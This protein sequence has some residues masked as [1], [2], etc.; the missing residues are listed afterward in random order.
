VQ[1]YRRE[2]ARG[3]ELGAEG[4][5]DAPPAQVRALLLDYERAPAWVSGVHESR[6]VS[7]SDQ[8]LVV[9]QRLVLPLLRDRDFTLRVSWGMEQGREWLRFVADGGAGPPPVSGAIRVTHHE[10]QWLLSPIDGGRRTHAVYRFALDLGGAVPM[11]LGKGRAAK[12]LAGLFVALN[13]Q[14]H[15]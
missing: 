14:L 5:L 15:R 1:V 3:I 2:P 4:D 11:W 8:E 7:R 6:I 13:R 10:G 9:Y 12:D